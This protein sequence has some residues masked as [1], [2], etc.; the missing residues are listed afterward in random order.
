MFGFPVD[1]SLKD[2]SW[3]LV[4]ERLGGPLML[5][6]SSPVFDHHFCLGQAVEEVGVEAFAAKCAVETFVTAVLP[7]LT[8]FDPTRDNL[9]FFQESLQV[10]GD[11]FWAVVTAKLPR[12]S[13]AGN[14]LA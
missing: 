13:I 6:Q 7:G 2:S 9:S 3:Q 12:A 4:A 8:W 10:V 11:D 1:C 14:E 5:I